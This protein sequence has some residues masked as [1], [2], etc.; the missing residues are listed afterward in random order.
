MLDLDSVDAH[1]F[2]FGLMKLP[3][4]LTLL[5][6][7][8]IPVAAKALTFS[9]W[10]AANFTPAQLANPAISGIVTDPDGDGLSNLAEYIS[11]GN[12]FQAD[13]Q[14]SVKTGL[15][16]GHLTLTYRKRANLAD[17]QVWL[18]GS[19]DLTHWATFNTPAEAQ[20]NV[21]TAYVDITLI[22]P[23][24]VSFRRFIR[25][26]LQLGGLSRSKPTATEAKM[27]SPYLVQL[28]WTDPN[29]YEYG[30]AVERFDALAKSW[31]PLAYL[32]A[33][34][35]SYVDNS[36][37]IATGY[38]YR[39]TLFDD[40]ED[41]LGSDSF[42]PRDGDNDGI[43]DDLEAGGPFSSQAG[44]YGSSPLSA[45]TD[46]D[47]IPDLW[48]IR[49]GFNPNSAAD[50]DADADGDGISNRDEYVAGTDPLDFF[51]G[52][53]PTIIIEGGDF[54]N[55]PIGQYFPEPIVAT[56]YRPDGT[57]WAYA[58]VTLTSPSGADTFSLS[59]AEESLSLPTITVMAD[60]QGQITVYWKV[61]AQ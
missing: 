50:A 19:D 36:A 33:D 58:P 49:N 22:D 39:I 41:S 10:Q 38:T 4:I 53:Q 45:D 35:I 30:Y 9:E 13:T 28:K 52:V 48:E 6:C 29:G 46:S 24:P 21:T 37:T 2:R 42:Q 40:G 8:G 27:I 15:V 20:S 34:T 12:P 7:L 3:P 54:Q 51:N 59:N 56:I 60:A 16:D 44:T 23:V 17:A 57:P 14:L 55:A 18:Q 31:T 32:D 11:T 47:G 43:P 61:G 25:L 26:K 5:I 1:S